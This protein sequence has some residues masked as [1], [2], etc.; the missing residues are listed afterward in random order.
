MGYLRYKLAI[1]S[2]LGDGIGHGAR[3]AGAG[4]RVLAGDEQA[5]VLDMIGPIGPGDEFCAELAEA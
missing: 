4:L 3:D 2:R 5:V 1:D